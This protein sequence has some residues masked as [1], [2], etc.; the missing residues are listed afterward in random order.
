MNIGIGHFARLAVISTAAGATLLVG[1]GAATADEWPSQGNGRSV[2]ET[3]DFAVPSDVDYWNPLSSR[4]R[5]SSPFGTSTRIVCTGF[6]G[7]MQD[8]WQADLDGN[9]HKLEIAPLEMPYA[10]SSQTGRPGPTHYVFPG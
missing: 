5:L 2:F 7:V 9:P 8:C 1:A 4:N 10:G 6:H 3:K